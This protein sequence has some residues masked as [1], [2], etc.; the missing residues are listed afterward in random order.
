MTLP[1]TWTC[2]IRAVGIGGG[3]S[4]PPILADQFTTVQP[5]GQITSWPP[6]LQTFWR[7][8]KGSCCYNSVLRPSQYHGI[9][10]PNIFWSHASKII[11]FRL[12]GNNFL[13]FLYLLLFSK[14]DYFHN[15]ATQNF[16]MIQFATNFMFT[17]ETRLF[18]WWFNSTKIILP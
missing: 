15:V 16:L 12:W 3:H 17:G 9:M 11:F 14:L 13:Y 7:P 18:Y 6:N 10:G 1:R 4:P 2:Q 8:C 5:G